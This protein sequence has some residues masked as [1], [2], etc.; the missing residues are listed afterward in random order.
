[1]VAPMACVVA[2]RSMSSIGFE[3]RSCIAVLSS[4]YI[5]SRATSTQS[6][7]ELLWPFGASRAGHAGRNVSR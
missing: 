4:K 5:K 6:G 3:P 2:L 1:M 7:S